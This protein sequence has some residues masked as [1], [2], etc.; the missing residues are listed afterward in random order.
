MKKNLLTIGLIALSFS[1]QAQNVLT[2]VDDTA[3]MYVSEGTLVYNGGGLQ[4]RGSGTIDLHGNMM[5]VGT[6]ADVVKT[7][8]NGG[9]NKTT[10]SNIIVRLNTPG[11]PITSTYGQ[12]YIKGLNQSAITGIVD[13]EYAATKHGSYQQIGIPFNGKTFASFNTE[14]GSSFDEKRWLGK[15]ILRWSNDNV[16]FDGSTIPTAPISS[17]STPGISVVLSTITQPT[18]RTAYYAVGTTAFN[19]EVIHTYKGSPYADGLTGSGVIN[20][21]PSTITTYGTGGNN[22]NFYR[23]KYNTYIGDAFENATPWVG[24]FGKYIYQYSNPYLTNL[25]LSLIGYNEPALPSD[26]NNIDNIHGIIVNPATVVYNAT[27]GGTSTYAG[28][29]MVTF[30]ANRKPTGNYD[31]LVVKPLGTF[32]IKLKTNVAKTLDFD[33]LRRFSSVPRGETVGYSVTAQRNSNAI[34]QLGV[35][36]LDAAGNQ[37]GETYYVVAPHFATGNIVDPLVNN[38][39][40]AMTSTDAIIQTFE[41]LPTGGTDPNF[42]SAYRLYINEA[43]ETNFTGKRINLSLFGSNVK[44]LKFQLR[45]DTQLV[46]NGTHLLSSGKGFYYTKANGQ[47]I[48]VR[49]GDLVPVNDTNYGLY[50]DTPQNV[51][52]NTND[53]SKKSRTIVTY[54]PSVENYIVRFDPDWKTA[55]VEVYDASGKLIIGEK[56]VKTNNDFVIKLDSKLKAMYVVKV[57]GNDGDIVNTKI[58]IK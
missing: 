28:A 3:V 6:A 54:N 46:A 13:R 45:D 1:V 15:E 47:A 35:L 48:E 14:S 8:D 4:T 9:V 16:R 12:L 44:F 51:V 39:V 11:S 26:N 17:A 37:I 30:D 32:K 5:V 22:T 25:D 57:V 21:T 24:T 56:S 27:T 29:Q 40:Q 7:I 20:L 43:N 42:A 49:Q 2:H 18:D 38:S 50:Y 41:E 34:K 19:P 33:N 52:L 53:I 31:A 55:S 58:L 10:G 36:A 23:E